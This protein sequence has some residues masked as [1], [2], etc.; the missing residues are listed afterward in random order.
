MTTTATTLIS[1]TDAG[2]R[3]GERLTG[4]IPAASHLHRPQ[5]FAE[6]LQARF[7]AGERLLCI[8]A[9]GIVMRS[10]APVLKDKH[11]DPAVL[12]I[13]E[14]ARFVVP[15]LSGHEGGGYAWGQA[16]A[17]VLG[18]HCVITGAQPFSR[19]ITA[20]GMGCERDCPQEQLAELMQQGL[21]GHQP[22][23]IA[24][25]DIKSDEQGLLAL[26]RQQ[27]LPTLFF[28]ASELNR[29]RERLQNPSALVYRETGCYG[30]AEAA[31]LAAAEQ[32][33]GA[34]AQL[35][36]PKI[37]SRRATFALARSY[38]PTP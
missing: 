3:L 17:A 35:L 38:L 4:L 31:A 11:H 25:I 15:L 28:S 26:A 14:D 2:Q 24:S 10:L 13:D 34:P 23:A 9:G 32:L 8:C 6:Q 20:I 21:A 19:P 18:A 12:L 22:A 37:K 33:S 5:P 27:Q 1:L 30:V 29:Y 7:R 16:L 36:I